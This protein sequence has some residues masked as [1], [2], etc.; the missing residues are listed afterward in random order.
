[1]QEADGEE[2]SGD[3]YKPHEA[4]LLDSDFLHVDKYMPIPAA[5]AYATGPLQGSTGG[6]LRGNFK[7]G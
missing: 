1:M 6:L 5:G 7:P 3:P 4:V 2:P